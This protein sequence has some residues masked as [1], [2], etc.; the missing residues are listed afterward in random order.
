MA[1]NEAVLYPI[2][3]YCESH[4]VISTLIVPEDEW[5]HGSYQVLVIREEVD[6]DGVAA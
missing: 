5:L 1:A 2:Y 3:A 4:G 6:R